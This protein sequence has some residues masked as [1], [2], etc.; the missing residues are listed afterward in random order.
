MRGMRRFF[1]E[2]MTDGQKTV[3]ITGDEFVH[4]R[5]VLRLAPGAEVSLFDGKGLELRGAIASMG[6]SSAEVRIEGRAEPAGES[7]L[8]LVLLQGL[9]KGDRPEL[10]V[11][12]ATELGARAVFFYTTSRTV[13]DFEKGER[14]G[15]WRDGRKA[16]WKLKRWRRAAIEAAKQCGRATVP[17]IGL[18]DFRG[19]L[20]R[21][22]TG[23]KLLL[24]EEGGISL[25]DA[26]RDREAGSSL[27]ALI[28]PEGGLALEEAAE[29]EA[30]GFV[31]VTMG[32]RVM[33]AETAALAALS[34][35]QYELGDMG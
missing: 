22:A 8:G 20:G 18:D 16:G 21:G 1:V 3:T 14:G 26:L 7:P 23:L 33:R 13:P 9:L 30:L 31:G 32:P 5:N 28:G 19:A 10:I 34:V 25:R 15:D 35:L 2:G 11:Q 27:T 17:A 4:L 6:R 24:K 29:A 12:K